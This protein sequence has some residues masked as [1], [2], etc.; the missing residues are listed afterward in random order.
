L[1]AAANSASREGERG[2]RLWPVRVWLYAMAGLVLLM[3]L[4]GGATR[5]TDSGLSITAWKPIAGIVPPLTPADWWTEFQAYQRIPEYELVNKGM[6]LNEFKAIFW[7]EWGHRAL[8]RLIGAAFLVPFLVFLWQ[9]RL[10]WRLAPA[11]AGL[12]VLGGLQGALGWWMVTSGLAERVDVSQYRLAAHLGAACALFL[13]LVWVARGIRP[14]AAVSADAGRWPWVAGAF[15]ALVFVQIVAGAFVAGL[16]AGL[17]YNTWPLMDGALV[18]DGLGFMDPF[19]VNLFE[20]PATAQFDHRMLGYLAAAAA[21]LIAVIGFR[22]TGWRGVQAW[23]PAI[24]GL[25]IVQMLL[26]I[27]TL[28]MAVPIG[29]AL[30]HQ[31]T[32]FVLAGATVAWLA[33][34]RHVSR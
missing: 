13:A 12:F 27:S 30:A 32:A 9:R 1:T 7:W 23:Q 29:L 17:A 16:D 8:G 24:A 18:P 26:G 11:L 25:T 5:L 2:D 21:I 20:N 4:V 15:L 10:S 14:P 28:V 34:L 6:G 3:V 22:R 33:D 31:G 19:W